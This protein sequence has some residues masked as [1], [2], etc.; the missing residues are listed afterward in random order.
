M[1][2]QLFREV[3]NSVLNIL[4]ILFISM[5]LTIQ[6]HVQPTATSPCKLNSLLLCQCLCQK[7]IVS[8]F[9]M[10]SKTFMAFEWSYC[11]SLY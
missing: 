10:L 11:V 9:E 5:V 2:R 4:K 8:C 1:P 6:A 7:D 3:K